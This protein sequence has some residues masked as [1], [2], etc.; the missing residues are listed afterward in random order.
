MSVLPTL[1]TDP[2][3]SI[4]IVPLDYVSACLLKLVSTK[5]LKYSIYN[6]SS[7]RQS[8][9]IKEIVKM[10]NPDRRNVSYDSEQALNMSNKDFMALVG[11][12]VSPRLVKYALRQY[13]YFSS[14]NV[15]FNNQRIVDLMGYTP[16]S[17]LAYGDKCNA[18]NHESISKQFRDDLILFSK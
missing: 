7:G 15:T 2:N 18:L 12:D 8:P 6:V 11:T 9:R 3:N 1:L 13:M 17:I 10:I 16:N 14:M 5:D 4:D